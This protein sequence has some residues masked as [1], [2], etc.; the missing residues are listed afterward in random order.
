MGGLKKIVSIFKF[1]SILILKWIQIF[2]KKDR[3]LEKVSFD[4][5]RNWHSEKSFLIVEL[6]FENAIYFKVGNLRK[7]EFSKPFVLNLELVATK[8]ISV[9]VFGFFQKQVLVIDLKKELQ[10]NTESFKTTIQN[11]RTFELGD[12]KTELGLIKPRLSA[13]KPEILNRNVNINISSIT[14]NFT[15]FKSQNFL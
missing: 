9:E 15:K 3:S 14:V 8:T 7:F 6:K 2:L 11:F 1:Q 10:T 12:H 4:Y 5:Y 13:L